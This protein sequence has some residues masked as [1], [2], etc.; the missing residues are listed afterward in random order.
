MTREPD[1]VGRREPPDDELPTEPR[2]EPEPHQ[3]P[4]LTRR[5]FVTRA[6][7]VAGVGAIAPFSFVRA[8]SART[9]EL[10]RY[11]RRKR[12]EANTPGIAVAVVRGDEVVWSAG[13]GW[14]DRERGI[15]ATSE[16]FFQLASVSKTVT[17]AGIM[18]LVEDHT[19]DL[20]ADVN[21]YLPFGVRVPFA[22]DEAVTM[23]QL[24]THTSAIRDRW[25]VWGTPWSEPSL[26]F[27]GDSPISLGDFCRSYFVPGEERYRRRKNFFDWAPG[28]RYAYSNLATA[29]A[30]FVAESA[31]GVDFNELC[32]D[33][34]LRPL[35][36]TDSGF[37]LA[38]VGTSN[39]A[40]PYALRRGEFEPIFHYGYPDYPDGALRSS[41]DQLARWLG[42]FMNFGAFEGARVLDAA[43]VRGIR[44]HQIPGIVDWRQG[45]IWYGESTWDFSMWGHTGGDYGQSTRMFFRPDRRVGVVSLTNAYLGGRRWGAFSEI[46]RRLF[47]GFS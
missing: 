21:T 34:I 30:G 24:L 39:L 17:C 38:D 37:R 32:K 12:V 4:P 33:R 40:M 47:R 5:E 6:A 18:A 31:S 14:A 25:D 2:S 27:D 1:Q 22:P 15:R 35:G 46:E 19:L 28:T 45:L 8:P 11:L 3:A 41:A 7:A 13:V 9:D 26:Y 29:L 44:H 43:T 42:A 23:R 36:M 20:D 10:K 16:T